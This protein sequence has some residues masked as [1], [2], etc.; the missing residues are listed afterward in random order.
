MNLKY[1]DL[2]RGQLLNSFDGQEEIFARLALVVPNRAPFL[3]KQNPHIN[4]P[5]AWL[6]SDF[7]LAD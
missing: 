4:N 3:K 2:L 1:W 7:I 6:H 5:S